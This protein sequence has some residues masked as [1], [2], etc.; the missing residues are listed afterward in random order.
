MLT[1]LAGVG[2]QFAVPLHLQT[3]ACPR[4]QERRS[5]YLGA[6]IAGWGWLIFHNART[7][8]VPGE[9]SSQLIRR[10]PY[11]FSRN[12]IMWGWRSPT[13]ERPGCPIRDRQT[14][15]ISMRVRFPTATFRT[16]LGAG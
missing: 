13:W 6:V 5:S 8:T 2:L 10:G 9:A 4:S 14:R 11:R 3:V 15:V 16:L 12:P 1:Y 7:T